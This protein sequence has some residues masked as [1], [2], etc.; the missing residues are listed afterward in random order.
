VRLWADS[1]RDGLDEI[2]DLDG[3]ARGIAQLLREVGGGGEEDVARRREA[4]CCQLSGGARAGIATDS[5]RAQ[6]VA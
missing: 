5:P 1:L 4:G 2:G 6:A 3:H